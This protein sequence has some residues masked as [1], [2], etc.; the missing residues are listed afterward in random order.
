MSRDQAAAVAADERSPIMP[1]FPSV[2]HVALTV[3]DLD[4]SETW[5]KALFAADPVLDEDTGGFYHKVWLLGGT[6]FGIHGH[7][8]TQATDRFSET[9]VGLDH[10]SFGVSARP[11]LETWETRLNELGIAHGGIVDAPYGSGLSFRDPDNNALE[12]FAPPA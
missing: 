6:L 8:Q 12:F 3:T 2:H 5:Y 4:R 7:K 1:A 11:E 9:R 10:V